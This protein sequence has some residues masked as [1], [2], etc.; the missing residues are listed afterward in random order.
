MKKT[1]LALVLMLCLCL[2]TAVAEEATPLPFGMSYSMNWKETCAAAGENAQYDTWETEDDEVRIGSIY[3]EEVDIGV[4]TL[5]AST[6]Y[7]EVND[8]NSAREGR[9]FD[10][11]CLLEPGDNVIASF[12]D[13][14]AQVSSVYGDPD[15]DPFDEE[16]VAA[17]VE[18][19][20][21][22]AS[23]TRTDVR[24]NLYMQ[25]AYDDSLSLEFSNRLCFNADDLK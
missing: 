6:V 2:A 11:L 8:S 13:A 7:F 4:G 1:L 17:Y 21:L 24:I 15:N 22:S 20:A 9:L 23:W 12:R 14:L 5:H 16:S 18:Y 3:V 10:V 19:G 25:R